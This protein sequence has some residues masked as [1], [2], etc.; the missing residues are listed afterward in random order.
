LAR[1]T[2]QAA[3]PLDVSI[4]LLAAGPND[5][6][7]TIWSDVIIGAPDDTTAL[8]DLAE[9]T[10]VVT[11]DH[12]LVPVATLAALEAAGH[13]LRPSSNTMALAQNK[14]LQRERHAALGLNVPAFEVTADPHRVFQFA[15][16][17]G[18]PVVAKSAQGGY[19]GRGVWV[20]R[21]RS[22]ALAF[23]EDVESGPGCVFVV[24]AFV[25]IERELAILV[26]RRPNGE[27][28]IYPLVETVQVDGICHEIIAPA[29]VSPE[30]AEEA[31]R[32][33]Q[34]VADDAGVTGVMA[35]ELFEANGRLIVNE[36]ATRP[37][38]SGH[39]TIEGSVTSQ[40]EQHLRAILDWPLGDTVLNAPHVVTVNLLGPRDGSDPVTRRI[41]AL[42]VPGVHLH[43]YGKEARP[44]RKLGHVTALGNDLE[45]TRDRAWRAATILTGEERTVR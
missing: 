17:H 37:H 5:G 2:L 14:R 6:A 4:R 25:P 32:I 10:T 30:L 35:I 27:Q 42:A 33:A 29:R 40:F 26:A 31:H 19:D 21:D 24:E 18:W 38:N 3:I 39:Y 1:M 22:A 36:I 43:F 41:G 9:T 12:E 28:A 20:L 44:G 11:F 7:A 8:T 15:E 16:A 34:V 45:E 23:I 13:A